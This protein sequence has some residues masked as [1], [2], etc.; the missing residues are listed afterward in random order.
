MSTHAFI[1]IVD[2]EKIHYIYLHHDGYLQHTGETLQNK[3]NTL[4]KVSK[5]LKLGDLDELSPNLNECVPLGKDDGGPAKTCHYMEFPTQE[6]SYLFHSG[7][8]FY[9][10]KKTS[11]LSLT[12]LNFVKLED[13]FNKLNDPQEQIKNNLSLRIPNGCGLEYIAVGPITRKSFE[14]SRIV[15]ATTGNRIAVRKE[16]FHNTAEDTD[17]MKAVEEALQNENLYWVNTTLYELSQ[18]REAVTDFSFR[19]VP[20]L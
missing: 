13:A 1:G 2:K 5:L 8:W 9:R 4:Q 7:S 16:V 19:L 11:I 17:L 15:I 10:D 3:Y 14:V 12:P 20:C 18:L 6:L